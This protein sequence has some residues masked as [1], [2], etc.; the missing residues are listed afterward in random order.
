MRS[1]WLIATLGIGVLSGCGSNATSQ[2]ASLP[3]PLKSG[4]DSQYFDDSVRPQD[5]LYR[6]VNGKWLDSFELPADKS[7]YD[8][9]YLI[10]DR[11]EEQ[12]HALIDDLQKKVDPTDP[13]QQKI[14][15]LYATFM[16][17]SAIETLGAKPLDAQ[18]R[19]IDALKSWH[20][21]PALIAHFNEIGATAPYTPTVHQDA[22]DPTQYVYDVAQDGL[23][24]PD[25][26]YYLLNDPKLKHTRDEYLAHIG[27]MLTLLGEKDAAGEAKAVLGLETALAKVSW[28]KVQNRDP[29]KTYN[30]VEIPK[31]AALAP[32]YDWSAYLGASGVQ[33]KVEYLVISQPSYISGFNQLLQHTP[34]PA[35]KAYF[36]YHLVT[37][38]APYLSKAF[39]DENF[40]F[41]G[42]ELSGTPQI[43]PRWKRGL[44]LID[45]SIGEGL[46][47]LYVARNFPPEAK[48]R[49]DALIRNLLAAFKSD[50]D[51]S[52]W[53]GPETRQ[54]AQEKLAKF[55][56]KIGYPDK[57][58]D[59]SALRIDRGDLVGDVTRATEFEFR[60][61]VNKLGKPLDR[62]E[63][64]MTAPTV[65]AYY[66]P[67][68][69]EIVFP[70]AILQPPFF[71]PQA[72]DAVNY[73]AIGAIIGHEIS[74]GFDDQGSQYDGDGRLL[75]APGWFTAE[76]LQHFRDRTRSLVQQYAAYSPV[77]GYPINGEL[78]LGENIADNSGL[79]TAYQAYRLSL[80]DQPAP[81]ID[82]LSGDQRFFM[83]FAQAWRG[84][85]RENMAIMLI[86]VDPHSPDRF[87]GLLPER[88]QDAFYA[89][90]D[91]KPEDKMYLA[92]EQR[93]H[94]W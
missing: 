29:V 73:G 49:A 79:A 53:M 90:F 65:N 22:H 69:N 74:H 26:D 10:S 58:R 43:R 25:R 80:K 18:L 1:P 17:E 39:V 36:R 56:T 13:D 76:D 71:D 24:M 6:H 68:F 51:K 38:Y 63:W 21:V 41:Q 81:V 11:V 9:F 14:A 19:Q 35:W 46:G 87:R 28:T 55:T 84:K 57:P 78:T 45:G 70:A 30:R 32:G 15:D 93:V 42:R 86:K 75:A 5:D 89:A 23:G 44:R 50:I 67:E 2:P 92:P 66:N 8:Q 54:K 77:P 85:T 3:P 4:L 88:N 60:R 33:G 34:V 61:N 12:L 37:H 16:D 20:D 82:G 27:R 94:L 62:T 59:Y 72:D 91:V 52:D 7:G 40:A 64:G 31:L 47:K 48:A 83:G